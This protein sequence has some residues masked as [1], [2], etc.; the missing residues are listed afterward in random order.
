ME[1]IYWSIFQNCVHYSLHFIVPF[2]VARH[3]FKAQWLKVILVLWATM[4][5]DVDHLWATPLFDPNRCSIG[6][7]PLHSYFAILAYAIGL[8]TIKNFW[9]KLICG[10]LLFHMFTDALDCWMNWL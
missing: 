1:S 8:I 4:L 2:F 6:F 5:V 9:V 7:H 10:G 3:F